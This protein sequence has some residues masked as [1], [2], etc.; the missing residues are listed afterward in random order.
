MSGKT[1]K[2]KRRTIDRHAKLFLNNC[3][4]HIEQA[5]LLPFGQN[6]FLTRLNRR[7]DNRHGNARSLALRHADGKGF[8][9]ATNGQ[10]TQ[11]VFNGM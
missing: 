9:N 11:A 8:L 6:A 2:G 1:G 10:F 4:R 7:I 5:L 3:D